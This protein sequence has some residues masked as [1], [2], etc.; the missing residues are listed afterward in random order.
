MGDSYQGPH[1]DGD[2]ATE[3]VAGRAREGGTEEGTA[4]E[5][6]H[7]GSRGIVV[8]LVELSDEGLGGNDLGDDTEIVAVQQR[9]QRGK[10]AHK[11]LV[12][13][14]RERHGDWRAGQRG[15]ESAGRT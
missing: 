14:G 3:L 1:Q 6:R 11:E 8:G 10:Q 12:Y 7:D 9:A 13:F 4:R 15:G 2:S 5:D